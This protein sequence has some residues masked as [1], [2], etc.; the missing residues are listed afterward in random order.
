MTVKDILDLSTD[1][2]DIYDVNNTIDRMVTINRIAYK[3]GMVLEKIVN[4]EVADIFAFT[5]V[6]RV[7]IHWTKEE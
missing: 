1:D 4:S 5:G 7:T 3:K 2:I 6:L